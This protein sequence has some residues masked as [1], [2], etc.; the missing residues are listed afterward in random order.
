MDAERLHGFKT[1]WT[2]SWKTNLLWIKY[3]DL[4]SSWS[5]KLKSGRLFCGSIATCLSCFK[6]F[7]KHLTLI[8]VRDK[9]KGLELLL[10]DSPTAIPMFLCC[11]LFQ[12]VWILSSFCCHPRCFLCRGI[13][14]SHT[15]SW[16]CTWLSTWCSAVDT[17]CSC[18]Y[19]PP[20][21]LSGFCRVFFM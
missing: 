7:R 15:K 12:C 3:K 10:V 20:A 1:N 18:S 14:K 16:C 8:I 6:L 17:L 19:L 13:E 4:A 11:G 21:A 9:S 2:N 5:H